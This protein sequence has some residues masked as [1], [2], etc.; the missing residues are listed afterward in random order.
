MSCLVKHDHD[1][2][3]FSDIRNMCRHCELRIIECTPLDNLDPWSV[4]HLKLQIFNC[5]D[6]ELF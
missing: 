5:E 1:D 3:T 6:G 4:A 2:G